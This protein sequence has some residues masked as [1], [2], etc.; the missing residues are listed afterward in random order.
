MFGSR[1]V[2]WPQEAYHFAE[3]THFSNAAC[4]FVPA[5]TVNERCNPSLDECG[6]WIAIHHKRVQRFGGIAKQKLPARF[7]SVDVKIGF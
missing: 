2:R 7:K 5:T 3:K 6:I 1:T 4:A